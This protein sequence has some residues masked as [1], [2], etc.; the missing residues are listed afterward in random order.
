MAGVGS[1]RMHAAPCTRAHTRTRTLTVSVCRKG[2]ARQLC[3]K[4]GK[5][6]GLPK[7]NVSDN[8]PLQQGRLPEV[9]L[10][11]GSSFNV[12]YAFCARNCG[13]FSPTV[14][15]MEM[16]N[17]KKKK[18]PSSAC[19]R[20]RVGDPAELCGRFSD[21]REAAG[22][23]RARARARRG[24]GGGLAGPGSAPGAQGRG[25]FKGGR[26]GGR[27]LSPSW[28][29]GRAA[30]RPLARGTCPGDRPATSL[31]GARLKIRTK[32]QSPSVSGCA[33]WPGNFLAARR[34]RRE[35]AR[36][37]RER[38]RPSP[39]RPGPARPAQA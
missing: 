12:I 39:V 19:P 37:A 25:P 13:I 38:G 1:D 35:G 10:Y 34:P 16:L 26:G 18:H 24:R 29:R 21:R 28:S 17:K 6:P 15:N 20:P 2:P 5:L 27:P 11:F 8:S 36:T 30:P 33:E 23:T 31:E 32:I 14:N 7:S 9:S 4:D 22:K 3:V